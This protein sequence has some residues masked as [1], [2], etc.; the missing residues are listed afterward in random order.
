MAHTSAGSTLQRATAAG[1]T[2]VVLPSAASAS[3][4]AT[5]AVLGAALGGVP[6]ILSEGCASQ[7]PPPSASRAAGSTLMVLLSTGSASTA[8]H[9][10]WQHHCGATKRWLPLAA[11]HSRW[12]HLRGANSAGSTSTALSAP[13]YA[14]CPLHIT[15]T[16][17]CGAL[18]SNSKPHA[19]TALI[20]PPAFCG[21]GN[22]TALHDAVTPPWC[23]RMR[24]TRA[25]PVLPPRRGFSCVSPPWRSAVL[26][27]PTRR[28]PVPHS[29]TESP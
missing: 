14:R 19:G 29:A 3:Q 12:Q 20:P 2:L 11:R 21:A 25:A 9:S 24:C 27:T 17:Y 26:V 23:S 13:W 22:T 4:R 6:H 1:N 5:A 10:R 7:H 28:C 15:R 18:H 8:R 16:Q